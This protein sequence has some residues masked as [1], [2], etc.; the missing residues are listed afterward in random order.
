MVGNQINQGVLEP[1][2]VRRI[3]QLHIPLL[4]ALLVPMGRLWGRHL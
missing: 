4:F 3:C 2:I 1:D